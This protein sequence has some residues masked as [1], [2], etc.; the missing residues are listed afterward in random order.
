MSRSFRSKLSSIGKH[1][2]ILISAFLCILLYTC[3]IAPAYISTVKD[4]VYVNSVLPL[5]L[6]ILKTLFE[7]LISAILIAFTVYSIYIENTHK[8]K[9]EQALIPFYGFWASAI[10]ILIQY[11]LNAISSLISGELTEIS[12]VFGFSALFTPL[13]DIIIIL[14][15]ALIANSMSKTH[16]I[17]AHQLRKASKYVPGS[18]YNE[19]TDVY[20][21]GSFISLKN[22]ILRPVFIGSLIM[23]SLLLVQRIITDIGLGAPTKI[24]EVNEMVFY[25]LFDIMQGVVAYTASYFTVSFLLNDKSADTINK[26]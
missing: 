10:L 2:L 13:V 8:Y 22:I 26:K 19:R 12:D 1:W 15:V 24:S 4:V 23:V 14:V 6:S 9:G 5:V 21:F 11:I 3:V 17:R 20:P 16:F 18:L 7:T 25:Y